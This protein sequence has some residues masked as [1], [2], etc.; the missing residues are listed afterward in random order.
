M[1]SRSVSPAG[2]YAVAVLATA[3]AILVRKIL[4]PWVGGF[5]PL[6]PMLGAVGLSMWFGGMGPAIASVVLGYLAAYALFIDPHGT[7]VIREPRELLRLGMYLFSCAVLIGF[8]EAMRRAN[9]R[10]EAAQIEAERSMDRQR[11]TE[12]SLRRAEERER[13][14]AAELEALMES[15]PA[16]VWIA[17]DPECRRITG[18]RTAYST[19]GA[20]PGVNLSASAPP[21]ERL[22]HVRLLQ[23][24]KETVPEALPMQV[25]GAQGTEVRDTELTLAFDDG[26]SRHL[27]GNAVPLR[28]QDGAVRGVISA[29]VDITRRKQVEEA[30]RRSEEQLHMVTDSMSA[31][32]SRCTRDLRYAWVSRPYAAWLKMAPEE[33]VGRPIEDVIGPEAFRRLRPYFIRVLDGHEV[34]YEERVSFQGLGPRWVHAVYSPT[35]DSAGVPDGWV[36]VVLDID[37]R[38][39][40]EEA[41]READR[42]KDEFLATLAHELR[43]PL[44]PIRNATQVLRIKG[45]SGPELAWAQDVIDRQMEHMTRLIDDLL[46]V[47]RITRNQIELRRERVALARI[48]RGAVETSR[49]LIDGLGHQLTVTLP[50]EALELDADLTRLAQVFANLL[51][52]AAKFTERGGSIGLG[53]ER[54]GSDVVVSVRDNGIG[55]PRE[56][57]DSVF[58]LFTQVDRSLERSR[59]GLGIGLTMVKRLVEMHGGRVTAHSD[60]PGLGSEFVVRLPLPVPSDVGSPLVAPSVAPGELPSCRRILVV[61]DNDDAAVGLGLLLGSLGYEVRTA[62]DGLAGLEAA[63]DFLPEVALLD[64][65]MPVMNG[66]DLARRIREQPWGQGMVLI[67]VTGWGQAGDRQRTIDA[68]FDDHLVKPVDPERLLSR[69]AL[70]LKSASAT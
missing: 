3:A 38:K 20:E 35:F 8:W 59:S 58:E 24:G 64:I 27:L 29:F 10:M 61:D 43:N 5:L 62:G 57:L 39:R 4:D 68:G 34:R 12:E 15:V 50:S 47:S 28:T 16:N 22:R 21:A 25:A 60:G 18:N 63:R 41:L 32:V 44:A 49:P 33:I 52:N 66:Y 19:L 54:Q 26:S 14:R 48:I 40:V 36:A 70:R 6:G 55:M 45:P 2:A 30:L 13:A 11:A 31:P 42:R 69:I 7:F 53:A 17:H 56:M 51:N 46:D 9:L 23:D 1:R 65:G 67:A 37:D